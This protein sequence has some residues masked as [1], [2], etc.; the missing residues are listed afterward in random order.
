MHRE[1]AGNIYL[2]AKPLSRIQHQSF[3]VPNINN[4]NLFL[5]LTD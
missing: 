1:M 2:L 3:C 4:G 5:K